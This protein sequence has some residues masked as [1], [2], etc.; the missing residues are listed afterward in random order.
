MTFLS[1]EEI[2][3]ERAAE[4]VKASRCPH[5]VNKCEPGTKRKLVLS[6]FGGRC[7]GFRT[8]HWDERTW[9]K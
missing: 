8:K 4:F 5:C 7:Y 2:E 1:I 9:A 6:A 3:M